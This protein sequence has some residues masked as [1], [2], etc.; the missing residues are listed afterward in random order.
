[1][2]EQF[3]VGTRLYD[4]CTGQANIPLTKVNAYRERWGLGPLDQPDYF[5]AGPRRTPRPE[6]KGNHRD[7]CPTCKK[8]KKVR[9]HKQRVS[10][11][12]RVPRHGKGLGDR[13]EQVLTSVGITSER[14]EGWLG[15]PCGCKKRKE[16]LNKLGDWVLRS[17]G[18]SHE[19][20]AEE[21]EKIIK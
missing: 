7:P 1:M 3:E 5:E 18:L 9:T 19:E 11:S 8:S 4:I 15:M 16:K 10:P 21:L 17:V 12:A 14:V 6:R 2:C 13:V 20:A